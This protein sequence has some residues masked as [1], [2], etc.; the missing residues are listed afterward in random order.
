[1]TSDFTDVNEELYRAVYPPTYRELFW[2]EDGTLS[3]AA[4][5]DPKCLSVDT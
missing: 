5:Y 2:K 3:S 4:F 1:M